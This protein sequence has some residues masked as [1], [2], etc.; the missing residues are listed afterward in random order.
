MQDELYTGFG[1]LQEKVQL[2]LKKYDELK[3]ENTE[4]KDQLEKLKHENLLL[5]EK[6]TNTTNKARQNQLA[7]NFDS[8]PTDNTRAKKEIEA[9]VR[10][11]EKCIDWLQKN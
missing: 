1:R 11:I 8:K 9:A 4:L 6:I 3:N 7:F 2:L 5:T 10:K